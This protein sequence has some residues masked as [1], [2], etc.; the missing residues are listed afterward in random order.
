[1]LE[2]DG[3]WRWMVVGG[4]RLLEVDCCWKWTFAGGGR[5]LKV[6]ADGWRPIAEGAM[7]GGDDAGE[8]TMPER[9]DGLGFLKDGRNFLELHDLGLKVLRSV[10]G[11]DGCLGLLHGMSVWADC[12]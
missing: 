8:R 2:V 5:L 1:M 12:W 7:A 6:D 10:A 3:S 4:G 11:G 9:G